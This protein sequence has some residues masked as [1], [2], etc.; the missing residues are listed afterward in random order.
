MLKHLIIAVLNHCGLCVFVVLAADQPANN[1]RLFWKIVWNVVRC[2]TLYS[3]CQEKEKRGE[4]KLDHQCRLENA[5][6]NNKSAVKQK[7]H[8]F[9]LYA[10]QKKYEFQAYSH[11]HRL[12]W[13]GA[14]SKAIENSGA[15]SRYQ[16]DLARQRRHNREEELLKRLSHMDIV[17]KTK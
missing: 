8:I 6:S 9:F 5:N 10:N 17:E 3:N 15:Q 13:M 4:I 11:R 16:L 14:L 1:K 12:E 7:S 2:L